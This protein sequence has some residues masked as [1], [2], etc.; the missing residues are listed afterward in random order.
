[1]SVE[2]VVPDYYCGHVSEGIKPILFLVSD[3]NM[4]GNVAITVQKG[5]EKE[6]ID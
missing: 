6:V 1:M 5:K 3:E 4:N 2:A